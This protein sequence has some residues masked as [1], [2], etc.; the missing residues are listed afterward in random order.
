M[1]AFR[2]A[3]AFVIMFAGLFRQQVPSSIRLRAHTAQQHLSSLLSRA[4]MLQVGSQGMEE[5]TF[6]LA[7]IEEFLAAKLA[8]VKQL[9]RTKE[10]C[11]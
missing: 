3:C 8:K 5:Y 11:F 10:E 2:G 7:R 1:P 4:L 9:F 6:P